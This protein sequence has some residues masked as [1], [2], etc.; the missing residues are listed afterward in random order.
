MSLDELDPQALRCL[1][2][3]LRGLPGAAVVRV[4]ERQNPAELREDLLQDLEIEP[5]AAPALAATG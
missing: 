1:S 3:R 2:R 4:V 5:S